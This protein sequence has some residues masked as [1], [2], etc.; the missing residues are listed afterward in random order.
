[1]EITRKPQG[2]FIKH[3]Y[4]FIY[5]SLSL[6][7]QMCPLV[8]RANK[9]LLLYHWHIF[10]IRVMYSLSMSSSSGVQCMCLE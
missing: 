6:A 5:C 7:M 8:V 1:M 9:A 10:F 3:M 2:S 4:L